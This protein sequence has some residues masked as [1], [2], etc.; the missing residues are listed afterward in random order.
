MRARSS[1]NKELLL[2]IRQA[3][4][5]GTPL[6]VR[7]ILYDF[8]ASK[9]WAFFLSRKIFKVILVKKASIVLL[10]MARVIG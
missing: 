10:F 3:L 9:I 4:G 7:K 5:R 2:L 1:I 6:F 8:L